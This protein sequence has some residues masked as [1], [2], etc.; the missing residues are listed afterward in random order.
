MTTMMNKEGAAAAFCLPDHI[1]E[2]VSEH[3]D[4]L[5]RNEGEARAVLGLLGAAGLTDLGAPGNADGRL[6]DMCSVIAGLASEC[7]SAAFTTWAN[8]MA[9]EYLTTAGTD[10]ARSLLP[11]LRDGTT[12]GITGMAAA[13]RDL[14]GCGSI[15][16]TATRKGDAWVLDGPIR[17]ASNLYDDAVLVTA[18]RTTTGDRIVVA[19]PLAS[20]GITVGQ[21]FSLLALNSTASS[22]LTLTDVRIEAHQ[23]LSRDFDTYLR[24]FRPTFLVLQTAVCV[25]LARTC[26]TNA[27]S[28]L[29]GTNAVFAG[30]VDAVNGKLSLVDSTMMRIAHSVGGARQVGATEVLAM[31]LAAAEVAT[32]AAALE[33]RTAGGKGY[34]GRSGASRRF[35]EAAFIPVQS[36]SEAQLRWELSQCGA[37]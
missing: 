18:A 20:A 21:P 9:I 26:L 22:F 35:R 16:V 8:R 36:P 27:R 14:S 13:F 33:V 31:R 24:S 10:Y 28:A 5:D 23:V 11:G 2:T 25:G 15:E 19:V 6:A 34:A 30:E 7:V 12:P 17:W 3:A 4:A 1:R 37:A 29:V 32:A